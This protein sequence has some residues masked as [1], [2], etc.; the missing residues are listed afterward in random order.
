MTLHYHIGQSIAGLERL[1]K[2]RKKIDWLI[3]ED[4]RPATYEELRVAISEAK[5]KGYTVLPPCNNV[6]N[7]G[8][9]QGHE[10][11]ADME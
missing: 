7:T 4:G 5:S 2:Q 9:C 8:H 11:I 1:V 3:N 10:D 6:S